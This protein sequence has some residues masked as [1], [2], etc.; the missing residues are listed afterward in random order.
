MGD[1][2]KFFQKYLKSPGSLSINRSIHEVY[3]NMELDMFNE[4]DMDK[5]MDRDKM[6][7]DFVLDRDMIEP[8]FEYLDLVKNNLKIRTIN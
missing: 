8:E 7:K 1:L 4:E 2:K 5:S 6:I 3:K